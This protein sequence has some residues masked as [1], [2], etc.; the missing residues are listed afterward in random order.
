VTP[1]P[2]VVAAQAGTSISVVGKKLL[3]GTAQ[4]SFTI[5]QSFGDVDVS[6][7]FTGMRIGSG[8]IRVPPNGLATASFGF[9][10]QNMTVLEDANAPYFSGPVAIGTDGIFAGPQGAIRL[11]GVEQGV[12][13]SVDI[14]IDLGL[15]AD[16]VV[17][18]D[19]VPAIF[20]G[21][22]RITGTVSIFLED[23]DTLNAYINESEVDLVVFVDRG[24]EPASFLCFNM[25]RVKLG[26]ATKTVAA[27]GG[28]IQTHPFTA[29]LVE[30]AAGT[31]GKD[32]SSLVIQRSNT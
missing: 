9:M 25:Q 8:A 27:Q 11:N 21:I 6:E 29:L 18:R 19:T 15:S 22:T 12:I 32:V 2:S 5:E 16:P 3:I 26:G 14:N 13:T 10:G 20:Y 4:K 1:S 31:T 7:L 24:A 28:V 23:A 17:G 30:G